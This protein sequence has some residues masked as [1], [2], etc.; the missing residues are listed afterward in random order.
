MSRTTVEE[1]EEISVNQNHPEVLSLS[2]PST[3][4]IGIERNTGDNDASE[5]ME[6]LSK[7]GRPNSSMM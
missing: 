2:Y 7:A 1:V 4:S 6:S 3:G 5:S